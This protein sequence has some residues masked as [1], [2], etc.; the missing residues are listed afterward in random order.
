M[1][2]PN[3]VVRLRPKRHDAIVESIQLALDLPLDLSQTTRD[4]LAS[5]LARF[6]PPERWGF[7]MLNPEQQLAV[8]KTINA[9]PKPATTLRVWAAVIAHIRYDGGEVMAARERLAQDADTTP[10]EVSR[11]LTRL[12][13]IGALQRLRPGRYSINPHVGWTGSL[14]A[15]DRAAQSVQP[16]QLALVHSSDTP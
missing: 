12:V 14:V 16:V 1:P 10:T 8:L 13:E 6:A 9:G 7:A 2:P 11:A 4:D 3:R 15:R 5:A